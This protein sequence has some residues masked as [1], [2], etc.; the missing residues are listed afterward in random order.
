[1][2]L[3]VPGPAP[4]IIAIGLDILSLVCFERAWMR[5]SCCKLDSLV[6]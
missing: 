1:M 5:L 3:P 6:L 2:A 4:A